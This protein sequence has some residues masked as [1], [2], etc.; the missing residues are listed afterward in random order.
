[1]RHLL[2]IMDLS[3]EEIDSLIQTAND[4]IANPAA[5]RGVCT[6]KKLATL[7]F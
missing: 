4:I 5:Y 2:D 7:F 3:V 6:G 1:M